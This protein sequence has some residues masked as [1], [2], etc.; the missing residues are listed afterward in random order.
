MSASTRLI[1]LAFAALIVVLLTA[2]SS[3]PM[4]AAAGQGST[5]LAANIP[6]QV[7]PAGT[8]P[9]KRVIYIWTEVAGATQYQI[10]VYQDTTRVLNKTLG[11][12]V[13][14]SGT[15]SF[16]HDIDLGNAKYNWRV[17]ATVGGA[18]QAYSP[19]VYFTVSAVT[20]PTGFYS[21]FTG[22]ALGWAVHKGLWYL[23]NS[24]FFTTTGAAGYIASISHT[25]DFS[26]FTYEAR[27][28]RDGCAANA[29]ALAIRGNPTLDSSGWWNTEYTFDYSNTGYFG[30]WRDY[31]GTYATLRDWTYS[32]A[33]IQGGWNTL[34]VKASGPNLYFYINDTLVWSG[35]D[36]TY[37]S[38]QVGI[39]MYRGPSCANDKL[40]VDYAKLDTTVSD[41]PAADM[42]IEMNEPTPGGT[43]NTAP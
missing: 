17:R 18:L 28:R 14:V 23:E 25:G 1:R 26:T 31:Y 10:Q 30:V 42:Q 36:T 8:I 13:C 11:S 39:A 38:G 6:A 29:N 9:I 27:M 16:R 33:I 40:W 37:A 15:C 43:R 32:S 34:K 21:P 2:A 41:L 19:W 5:R 3:F 7:F 35:T 24:D 12:A 22:D 20:P 4:D